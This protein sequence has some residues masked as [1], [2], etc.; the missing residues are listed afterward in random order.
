VPDDPETGRDVLKLLGNVLAQALQVPAA[1]RAALCLREVF[2]GFARQLRG[3]RMACAV[4]F[5][6]CGGCRRHMRFELCYA[7]LLLVEREFELLDQPL[8]FLAALAKDHPPELL[9]EQ[10]QTLDFCLLRKREGLQSG[11]VVRQ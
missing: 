4:G 11:D 10:L 5:L 9:D 8:H 3:Q 2:D 7:L 6:L 1:V